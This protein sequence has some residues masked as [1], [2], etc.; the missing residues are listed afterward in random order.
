MKFAVLFASGNINGLGRSAYIKGVVCTDVLYFL[1]H[2][3]E[4]NFKK[5]FA[6]RLLR[7]ISSQQASTTFF[8]CSRY[9]TI[10]HKIQDF[11]ITS[12]TQG[13]FISLA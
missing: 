11:Y 5:M 1:L 8:V 2:L 10:M 9:K 4:N 12:K 13:S 6:R 7:E 3:K